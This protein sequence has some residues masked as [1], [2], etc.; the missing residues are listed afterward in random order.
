MNVEL[1]VAIVDFSP[2]PHT[3]THTD[4][5]APFCSA[6]HGDFLSSARCGRPVQPSSDVSESADD[7]LRHAW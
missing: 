1:I 7:K 4:T 2:L 6:D 5:F 3:H